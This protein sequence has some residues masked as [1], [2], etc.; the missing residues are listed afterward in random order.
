MFPKC[1]AQLSGAGG[2]IFFA[3]NIIFNEIWRNIFK[4]P[5]LVQV[6]QLSHN[7]TDFKLVDHR[8]F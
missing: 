6:V 7:S 5:S 8:Q 2:P 4:I 1:E 3:W